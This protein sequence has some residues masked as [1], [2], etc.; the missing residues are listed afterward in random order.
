[1][2]TERQWHQAKLY[3]VGFGLLLIGFLLVE[4]FSYISYRSHYR[5]DNNRFQN[6]QQQI[7]TNQELA[8]KNSELIRQNQ[9]LLKKLVQKHAG[10]KQ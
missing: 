10:D 3:T 5:D 6:L 9:E 8:K 7:T 1:M 4:V 2:V